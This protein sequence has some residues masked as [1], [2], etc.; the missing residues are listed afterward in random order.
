[1]ES[2]IDD[3]SRLDAERLDRVHRS[4]QV[5]AALRRGTEIIAAPA[6]ANASM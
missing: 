2:P 1:V 4:V 3:D 6:S 5:R